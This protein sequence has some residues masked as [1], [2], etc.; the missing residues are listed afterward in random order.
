[1]TIAPSE[2]SIAEAKRLLVLGEKLLEEAYEL[3]DAIAAVAVEGSD[4]LS[5][6]IAAEVSEVVEPAISALGSEKDRIIKDA[7]NLIDAA[8]A[9]LGSSIGDGAQA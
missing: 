5:R 9:V 2:V 1:M 6:A 7:H 3:P 8:K 4:P